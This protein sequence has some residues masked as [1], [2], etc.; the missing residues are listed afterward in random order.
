MFTKNKQIPPWAA[1]LK[2]ALRVR[3]GQKER[4]THMLQPGFESSEV[5]RI[6]STEFG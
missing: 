2:H 1:I 5:Q 4:T 6:S 3:F